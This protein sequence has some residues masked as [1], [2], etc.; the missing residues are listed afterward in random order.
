MARAFKV[1]NDPPRGPVF[2]ALPIDV[3]EQDTDVA[4]PAAPV[5]PAAPPLPWL[6]PS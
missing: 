5:A 1:A 2:V 6:N 4:A 3:M